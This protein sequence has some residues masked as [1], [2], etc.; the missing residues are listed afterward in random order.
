MDID[1]LLFIH[2]HVFLKKVYTGSPAKRRGCRHRS[3]IACGRM[4]MI[5]II[6]RKSRP[7]K[8]G[9]FL[10][11]LYLERSL[12]TIEVRHCIPV[13]QVKAGIS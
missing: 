7:C 11:K 12:Q 8:E 6:D 3:L 13:P 5:G 9:D 2:P 1:N 4:D 10:T